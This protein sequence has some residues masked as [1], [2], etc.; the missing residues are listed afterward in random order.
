MLLP[1]L[2]RKLRSGIKIHCIL[3]DSVASAP[4]SQPELMYSPETFTFP[5]VAF[6][7]L[8]AITPVDSFPP[9]SV[10]P[11]VRLLPF[12]ARTPVF[13][14]KSVAVTVPFT[15]TVPFFAI[16]VSIPFPVTFPFTVT[17]ELSET[18]PPETFP[19]T[20][21][22]EPSIAIAPGDITPPCSSPFTSPSTTFTSPPLAKA[23]CAY[24]RQSFSSPYFT[25]PFFKIMLAY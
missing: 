18:R 12:D 23:G 1:A 11:T 21:R 8:S 9:T 16:T 14:L 19:F 17:V 2:H 25:T 15:V 5:A 6:D 4:H 13:S 10:S 3:P 22:S 20:F 7:P 24:T